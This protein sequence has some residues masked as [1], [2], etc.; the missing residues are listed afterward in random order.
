MGMDK[1]R[2]LKNIRALAKDKGVR[3]G[4]LES[5]CGVSVGYLARFSQDKNQVLPGTDFL[6][7][8]AERLEVSL[9]FLLSSDYCLASENEKYC[10]SFIS[11]LIVDTISEKV[12]WQS[13]PGCFPSPLVSDTL[14]PL[15]AH[16]LLSFDPELLQQGKSREIYL[17]PFHPSM[18]DLYPRAAWRASISETTDI[19][20]VSVTRDKDKEN[21]EEKA[22]WTELELYMQDK[23]EKA[24]AALCHTNMYSRGVLDEKIRDLSETVESMFRAMALPD[25]SRSAIDSYLSA[26][27]EK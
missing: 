4:D 17:S 20:L 19:L 5:S 15:P 7:R 11:R 1:E 24:F 25:W 12:F 22:P 3:L 21:T 23:K 6:V 8:A 18:V 10:S 9:D 2:F 13:D 27:S 14:L 16:P 26:R